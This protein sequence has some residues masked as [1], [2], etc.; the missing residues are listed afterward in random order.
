ML[1]FLPAGIIRKE[2]LAKLKATDGSGR[3]SGGT[4]ARVAFWRIGVPAHRLD[5]FAEVGV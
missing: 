4:M 5:E 2:G 1:P 3:L